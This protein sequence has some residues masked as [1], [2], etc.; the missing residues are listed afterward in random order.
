[1]AC[2]GSP[3]RTRGGVTVE[4]QTQNVPLQR[5]GVLEL[6]DQHN[7]ELFAHP[8][9]RDGNRIRIRQYTVQQRQQ[10]VEVAN[11]FG[12]LTSFDLEAS[13]SREEDALTG[14][15]LL[16]AVGFENCLTIADGASGDGQRVLR[17][18]TVETSPSGCSG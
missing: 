1:M 9:T 13:S 6:V 4:G 12:P 17:G 11:S 14:C 3:T 16:L 18:E 2:L 8:T 5:I 7:L 10:I 15:G